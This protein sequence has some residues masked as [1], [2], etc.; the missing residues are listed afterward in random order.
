MPPI[1]SQSASLLGA[2][3]TNQS[4]NSP[5]SSLPLAGLGGLS[6]PAVP[7]TVGQN[8][9]LS[10]STFITDTMNKI[11]NDPKT[12]GRLVTAAVVNAVMEAIIDTPQ[13]KAEREK[14]EKAR[15][16]AQ[17]KAEEKRK[18]DEALAA[19]KAETDKQKKDNE[20]LE[21]I[22]AYLRRREFLRGNTNSAAETL[23]ASDH[24]ASA[25]LNS[26]RDGKA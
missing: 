18:A 3:L 4:A 1:V 26:S 11:V 14:A 10:A 22:I 7:S 13:E 17:V 15:A 5:V 20:R 6:L 19:Q 2:A 12:P 25:S 23:L 8:A 16:E 21:Q 9:A 24:P